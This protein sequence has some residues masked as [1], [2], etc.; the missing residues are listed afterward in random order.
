MGFTNSAELRSAWT[1]RSPVTTRSKINGG[2]QECP[3]YTGIAFAL[4]MVIALLPARRR[5]YP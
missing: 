3:P 2:G 4:L 5:R 1:G